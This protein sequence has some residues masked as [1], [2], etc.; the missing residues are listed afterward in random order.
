MHAVVVCRDA[1]G[2]LFDNASTAAALWRKSVGDEKMRWS[3]NGVASLTHPDRY[4]SPMAVVAAVLVNATLI[5]YLVDGAPKLPASV[6]A[7]HR[8]QLA[9]QHTVEPAHAIL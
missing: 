2:L 4:L 5:G 9:D 3:A 1:D 8:L 7:V 6:T